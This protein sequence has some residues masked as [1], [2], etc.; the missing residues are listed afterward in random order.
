MREIK[1]RAWS[2]TDIELKL[3][4]K[5]VWTINEDEGEVA[6]AFVMEKDHEC[7]YPPIVVFGDS[8]NWIIEQYTGL[9]DKNG[10]EIY[11]GDIVKDRFDRIM[12]VKWWNYRLCWVAISETNFHHADLFDWCEKDENY[13]RTDVARVQVIGNIHE[14]PELLNKVNQ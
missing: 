1:F 9:Q 14:N 10:K 5:F 4:L 12:Q 13:D 11:E 7:T 8:N 2:K 6:F 3:P